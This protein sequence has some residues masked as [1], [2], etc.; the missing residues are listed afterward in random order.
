[1]F[2]Q[3]ADAKHRRTER[4]LRAARLSAHANSFAALDVPAA[5][6]GRAGEAE[7]EGTWDPLPLVVNTDGAVRFMGAEVLTAVVRL[8]GGGAVDLIQAHQPR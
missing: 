8:P 6:A 3:R 4:T 1:M 7:E 5:R 2:G